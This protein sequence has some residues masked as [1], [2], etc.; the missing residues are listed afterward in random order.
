[1]DFIVKAVE[2][3][4]TYHS[5]NTSITAVSMMKLKPRNNK[6]RINVFIMGLFDWGIDKVRLV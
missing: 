4:F 3:Y 1:L 2:L 6:K 5:Q